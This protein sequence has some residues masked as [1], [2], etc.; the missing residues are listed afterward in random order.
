ML[1]KCIETFSSICLCSFSSKLLRIVSQKTSK[2]DED[3]KSFGE[4]I[5]SRKW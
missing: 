1:C 4:T 5:F 2:Y 3:F